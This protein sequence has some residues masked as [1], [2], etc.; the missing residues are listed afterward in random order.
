MHSCALNDCFEFMHSYY[1]VLF[2]ACLFFGCVGSQLCHVGSSS[3]IR[4]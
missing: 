4:G 2:F 1:F 3:L